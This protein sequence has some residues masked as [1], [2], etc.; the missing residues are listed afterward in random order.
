MITLKTLPQ[1]TAQGV[2]EQVANHLIKQGVKSE[3]VD[4][5]GQMNCVYRLDALKCAA[6]CLIA[7]DEYNAERIEGYSWDN[8]VRI[9]IIPESHKDLICTLQ[10][11]H[12]EIIVANWKEKLTAV[13]I[14]FNLDYSFLNK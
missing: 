10:E 6:G 2:F 1:A 5:N 12:D 8:L 4:N 13:A 14:E 11:V 3:T 9:G 7:E